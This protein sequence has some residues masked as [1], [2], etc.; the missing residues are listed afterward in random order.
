MDKIKVGSVSDFQELTP[1]V[2]KVNES[3][4]FV[5]LHKGNF[6][7]YADMC[8]HQGGP[9]CEGDLRGCVIGQVDKT[10]LYIESTSKERFS[11]VCPWHG[12][13]YD[14]EN[15]ECLTNRRQRLRRFNVIVE[16]DDVF[17]VY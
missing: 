3:Q 11:I 12:V 14:L 16:N 15:G 8:P 1:K 10:G 4:V 9:A 7:A 2:A 5:Y 17:L 6:Y 13:E